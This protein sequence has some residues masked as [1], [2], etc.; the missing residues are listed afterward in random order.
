MSSTLASL[1]TGYQVA[2]RDLRLPYFYD[3]ADPD[4]KSIPE[5]DGIDSWDDAH[6]ECRRRH[7]AMWCATQR[8]VEYGFGQMA[9]SRSRALL[10]WQQ[11]PGQFSH[12]DVSFHVHDPARRLL[13]VACDNVGVGPGGSPPDGFALMRDVAH[14]FGLFTVTG[15]SERHHTQLFAGSKRIWNAN[16]REVTTW[17]DW[18]ALSG[19]VDIPPPPPPPPLPLEGDDVFVARRSSDGASLLVLADG[20]RRWIESATSNSAR[21]AG[22]A[23]VDFTDADFDRLLEAGIPTSVDLVEFDNPAP[24]G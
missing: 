8:G 19:V 13:P 18:P 9:R 21:Q 20:S 12:P 22:A 10:N 17:D 3:D 7:A 14:M 24:K 2:A 23:V 15:A 6:P 4:D 5:L 1:P 11:N 16:P